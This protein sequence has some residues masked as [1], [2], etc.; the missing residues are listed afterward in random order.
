MSL[1]TPAAA[2][3][4]TTAPAGTGSVTGRRVAGAAIAAAAAVIL[5]LAAW[6]EPSPTG[7][8]THR[9]AGLPGCAWV[10][11]MDL[12]CPTCGMTTA[13][14]HAANG[15]LVSSFLAQ[16]AGFLLAIAAAA[17]L[18]AGSWV[19]ISGADVV[20]LLARL[21]GPRLGIAAIAVLLAAWVYKILSYKG[22]V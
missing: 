13:F 20:S 5:G 12:P 19:A 11:F 1:P 2:A 6:L 17:A 14:A 4:A 8:G 21:A 15:D 7:L 18:L 22:V 3:P 10:T 16:P 9:Q